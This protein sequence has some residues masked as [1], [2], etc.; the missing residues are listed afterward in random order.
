MTIKKVTVTK[1]IACDGQEFDTH[2]VCFAH[3]REVMNM[4]ENDVYQL[5][6]EMRKLLYAINDARINARI[7]WIDAQKLK[8][9]GGAREKCEYCALMS[10]YWSRTADYN[11]RRRELFEVRRKISI[12]IDNLYMWFGHH[13]K[14]SSVARLE[15][16]RRSDVWRQENTPDKWRT[17]NKIRVGKLKEVKD[18]DDKRGED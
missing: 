6:C 3:E 9:T 11:V 14:K 13:K 15:R 16:K 2:D 7:S 17:P 8:P 5:Q 10:S 1:Y 4:L 12:E 18:A